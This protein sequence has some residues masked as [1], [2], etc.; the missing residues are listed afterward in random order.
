MSKRTQ[1]VLLSCSFVLAACGD[2]EDQH[3]H[4]DASAPDAEP[5]AGPMAVTIAFAAEVG[6][7][8]FACGQTYAGLGTTA[9]A[10]VGTDFRFYVHDVRLMMHGDAGPVEV[11]VTLDANDFQADGVALL[12]F[13]TGGTGCQMGST[14]THTAI[15]GTVPAGAYGGI[16]FKVGIPFAKNHLDVA[17]AAPPLN[18]PAMYWAWK[19]GL[20]VPQGRRHGERRG[21]QPPPRLDRLR[22]YGDDRAD[23]AVHEPQRD[24]RLAPWLHGRDERDRGGRRAR[25][26][27][28]R[29]VLQHDQ[30]RAGLHVVPR[31]SRVRHDP[32][33]ARPR[34]RRQP[35]GRAGA[36]H[37]P[38]SARAA[39]TAALAL[40]GACSDPAASPDAGVGVDA[41]P[42]AGAP[43]WPF[44]L[45]P[46][47]PTPRLPPGAILTP[48]L[49]ELGRHLFYD[50]RLSGNGTQAC[51]SCHLQARAFTDGLV[52][53]IGS[54]G[55]VLRR[56]SMSL[57][58]VAYNPNQTWASSVLVHLEQQALVPMFGDNPIELGI[59]GSEEVVL[60]RL[61]A[62]ASYQ[63]LFAAAFPDE[64]E[65]V[66]FDA[67]VAAITAFERR[68]ISAR[69]ALDRFRQGDA[70]ALS[71]S[72]RRGEALF[73]SETLE[74]H[75]CHGSFNF[76]I[77]VDHAGL[78]EP[79]I[80]FFNTGLYDVGG[81]GDYPAS[82]QGLYE[83]TQVPA[84]RGR[85][86]PPTLRN[87]ALTAP[88]MHD[89]SMATLDEVIR[90]Y[91][92]GGRLIE[93]GPNAG[94][95]K[96][97]RY[98]NAFV[99]G[100]T[101]TDQERADLRSFLEA[102]TDHEFVTD[103]TLADPFAAAP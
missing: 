26:R 84:D 78:A 90:F 89:G 87:I 66:R 14:S 36:V 42:D 43:A 71:E 16:A 65:P 11:P 61:R 62:D 67:I 33:E 53:P 41:S 82:D 83:L 98:K 20:Q 3:D 81:T 68:L 32:A 91:E 21:L 48:E 95:G 69:S 46:G 64:A 73:F 88:Y 23:R 28:G 39:T 5:D 57:T 15:T 74:C 40:L 96:L 100:F 8:P 52:A 1:V 103:P 19:L 76:T 55:E 27:R 35:G 70:T 10:Y 49:A 4:P 93:S 97:N 79:S 54:T 18:I 7:T 99:N 102:L 2:N 50:P 59:T 13:E 85:F 9:A 38:M 31:G 22:H 56:N 86:R 60:G 12:D 17:T 94:D 6:G 45:P 51:S 29:R 63:G 44:E 77:A 80:A 34:L 58:N 25:A 47:M 24:G 72:A 30:H 92:R 37:G 75:H 101:L